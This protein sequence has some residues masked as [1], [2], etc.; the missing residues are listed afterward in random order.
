MDWSGWYR[1]GPW[2]SL[3]GLGLLVPQGHHGI[4]ARRPSRG[5]ITRNHPDINTSSQATEVET[6]RTVEDAKRQLRGFKKPV[7]IAGADA[8]ATKKALE[9][10]KG[11]T[12][13][14]RDQ[15]GK[16]LKRSTRKRQ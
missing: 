7:Y 9:S 8:E 4:Y 10:T 2:A 14:V 1:P 11:T 6:A 12:I 5:Q 13:G 3:A 15:S 16:I